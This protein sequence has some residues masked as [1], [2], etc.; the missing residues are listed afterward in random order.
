[1]AD[2]IPTEPILSGSIADAVENGIYTP[3]VATRSGFVSGFYNRERSVRIFAGIPYAAA[4]VGNLRWKP[5]QPAAPWKGLHICDHFSSCAMQYKIPA[6]F[7]ELM[8]LRMGTDVFRHSVIAANE[9]VSEDCLYLNIWTGAKSGRER[10]PVII[11]IHGGM[12]DSGSGS[13]NIYDGESMAEKGVVFVTI[14]Y[15]L[16]IFGFLASPWLSKESATGTSGNYGILDQISAI[17]WVKNNIAN[18]GGDP[19][20]ITIA[21]ES[22]GSMCVN[23][24]QASPLASGLFERAVGESGAVFG[25][26]GINYAPLQTLVQ[27]E[28]SGLNFARS[29]KKSSV[30]DLRGIPAVDLQKASGKI[31]CWPVIDGYVLPDTVYNIYAAGKQNDVPV[32]IGYN[33]DEGSLFADTPWPF[34]TIPEFRRMRAG[35][36]RNMIKQTYGANVDDF[37]KLYPGNNDSEALISAVK[38][39]TIH[40]FAWHMHTWAELQNQTG[41]SKAYY[42]CFDHTQPGPKAM[43]KLGAYHTSE[44]AYFYRNLSKT[45]LSYRSNDKKL[46]DIMSSYL[47]NFARTGNPNGEGLPEWENYHDCDDPIMELGDIIGPMK[48]PY[49]KQL[50]FFD[51]FEAMVRACRKVNCN[52]RS[53]KSNPVYSQI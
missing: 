12:F 41:K 34:N 44:I 17:K 9:K 22:A 27:A 38:S 29:L 28:L 18:F 43:H 16:G 49:K 51:R 26:W 25:S 3:P 33:A 37:L 2:K 21:G 4:P 45:G 6:F 52:N 11:Y 42:Y 46:S 50:E 10:R 30:E 31:C 14:N 7:N 15:R 5:P 53:F 40:S 47:L 48:M 23:I 19:D 36:F 8:Y 39:D 24:L 35:K 1:M 20:N 13:I 32:L